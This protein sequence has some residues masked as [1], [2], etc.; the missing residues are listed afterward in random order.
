MTWIRNSWWHGIYGLCRKVYTNLMRQLMVAEVNFEEAW[1]A[2][3]DAG[4]ASW[5]TLR[6]QHAVRLFNDRLA[7]ELA[8]PEPCLEIFRQLT[9]DQA[10][11]YQVC[12]LNHL[13]QLVW[14]QTSAQPLPG[15]LAK[16]CPVSSCSLT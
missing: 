3:F 11:A 12:S 5:R 16:H 1:H 14:A 9:R 8:E 10:S 7:S 2:C 15:W 4:L 6:T 13:A